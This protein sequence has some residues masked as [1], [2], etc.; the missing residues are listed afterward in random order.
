MADE[1]DAKRARDTKSSEVANVWDLYDVPLRLWW[2][3]R[4]TLAHL[5][6]MEVENPDIYPAM[7]ARFNELYHVH[8][9][10]TDADEQ[11]D[12]H[13]DDD[14]HP[15]YFIVYI[16]RCLLHGPDMIEV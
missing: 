5:R 2:D 16:Q 6:S 14:Y 3:E 13:L 15:I 12:E 1:P 8:L 11:L 9:I 4:A 10:S 7:K